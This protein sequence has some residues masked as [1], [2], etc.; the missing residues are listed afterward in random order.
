MEAK[1]FIPIVFIL[2]PSFWAYENYHLVKRIDAAVE[3]GQTEYEE[4][5]DSKLCIGARW[6]FFDTAQKTDFNI[7]DRDGALHNEAFAKS[8]IGGCRRHRKYRAVW[9]VTPET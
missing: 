7:Y 4:F 1:Y 2:A 8:L 9:T 6:G 5:I 3:S